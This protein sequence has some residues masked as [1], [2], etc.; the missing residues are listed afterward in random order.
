MTNCTA[1]YVV[2]PSSHNSGFHIQLLNCLS[3]LQTNS[4]KSCLTTWP[5]LEILM[6]FLWV[7]FLHFQ[8]L[9]QQNTMQTCSFQPI[10]TDG[11]ACNNFQRVSMATPNRISRVSHVKLEVVVF[12]IYT[13]DEFISN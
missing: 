2:G 11:T 8:Y 13:V 5:D 4:N 12:E 3:I 9:I 6:E 1:Q 7:Y 10:P